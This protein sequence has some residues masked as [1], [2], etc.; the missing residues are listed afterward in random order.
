MFN[1]CQIIEIK[2][3]GG[4]ENVVGSKCGRPDARNRSSAFVAETS[5]SSQKI[6]VPNAR[7]ESGK[8]REKGQ[9]RKFVTKVLEAIS[10]RQS[11]SR[12]RSPKKVVALY[13][14]PPW[15]EDDIAGKPKQVV[16]V[17]GPNYLQE[18]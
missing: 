9:V 17:S 12:C 10:R 3:W 5:H 7:S 8:P 14:P 16:R 11:R 6:T 15:V 2:L 4:R 18:L 13:H 1:V